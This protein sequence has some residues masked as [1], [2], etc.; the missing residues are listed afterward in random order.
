MD[1]CQE[2]KKDMIIPIIM[3]N[4]LSQNATLVKASAR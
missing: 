4:T 3:L 1:F 2:G